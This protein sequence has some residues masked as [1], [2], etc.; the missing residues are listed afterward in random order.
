MPLHTDV[1]NCSGAYCAE[2]VQ[3]VSL[4]MQA[5]RKEYKPLVNQWDEA[6][7]TIN[8]LVNNLLNERFAV[9]HC[10]NRIQRYRDAIGGENNALRTEARDFLRW[11]GLKKGF[12]DVDPVAL[13]LRGPLDI[14]ERER[15]KCAV[16][17]DNAEEALWETINDL[18]AAW[19]D[20]HENPA[21][22]E[23]EP[24][25]VITL[26]T[27]PA[28]VALD[29]A[30]AHAGGAAQPPAAAAGAGTDAALTFSADAVVVGLRDDESGLRG[31]PH[32][33]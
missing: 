30:V 20:A 12:D 3:M 21:A 29:D 18:H 4:K 5:L 15:E 7:E 26:S 19:K 14:I 28:P 27:L 24:W 22:P 23:S 31:E 11:H 32:A 33:F 16:A 8:I 1:I 25:D 13:Y 6:V 2:L 17:L 9:Q 10:E